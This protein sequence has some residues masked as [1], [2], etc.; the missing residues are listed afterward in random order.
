MKQTTV[1]RIIEAAQCNRTVIIG[2][3][4]YKANLNTG[5][6]NRCLTRETDQEWFDHEGNRCNG[7]K[8]LQH[9]C[10]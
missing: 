8:V 2:K 4:T 10:F 3:Y 9:I 7:W 5:E 1:A 6:I